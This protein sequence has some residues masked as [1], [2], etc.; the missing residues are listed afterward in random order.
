M[1]DPGH[2]GRGGRGGT[3][4][5]TGIDSDSHVRLVPATDDWPGGVRADLGATDW[6]A[7][8][9]VDVVHYAPATSRD[10]R[11]VARTRG[12]TGTPG[13]RHR[14]R[15]TRRRSDPAGSSA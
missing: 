8:P 14:R 6:T 12:S 7:T 9:V 15:G 1:A 2:D 10:W 5:A 3:R 11:T 13:C 4:V